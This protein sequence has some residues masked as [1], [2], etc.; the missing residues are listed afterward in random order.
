MPRHNFERP[1]GQYQDMQTPSIHQLSHWVPP[2]GFPRQFSGILD[3][4]PGAKSAYSLRR[5]TKNYKGPL[6]RGRRS[7]D[8]VEKDFGFNIKNDLDIAA[9]WD[10]LYEN[11]YFTS[12]HI[13]PTFT[14][15]PAST[16]APGTEGDAIYAIFTISIPINPKDGGIFERGATG[17]GV[18]FWI[19]NGN[20]VW[21]VG[22]GTTISGPNVASVTVDASPYFGKTVDIQIFA[23]NVEDTLRIYIREHGEDQYQLIGST[24]I[25]FTNVLY[26]FN[27][28][29][30]FEI[31]SPVRAGF[32]DVVSDCIPIG[33][34]LVWEDTDTP[35]I[36]NILTKTI[37]DLFIPIWYD[38]SGNI[39]DFLQASFTNQPL[40]ITLGILTI[41][42]KGL[43]QIQY[44]RSNLTN[45]LATFSPILSGSDSSIFF[46]THQLVAEGGNSGVLITVPVGDDNS[47]GSPASLVFLLRSGSFDLRTIRTGLTVILNDVFDNNS[48][49]LTS[50]M[51]SFLVTTYK[52]SV[53]QNQSMS[54]LNAL[55]TDR[56]LLGANFTSGAPTSGTT[57]ASGELLLYD[58]DTAVA[59]PGI[60][61]GQIAYWIT[62][63]GNESY[64]DG[65][66]EGD[67]IYN[68]GAESGEVLVSTFLSGSSKKKKRSKKK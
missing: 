13:A 17:D 39:F 42:T 8:D 4:F 38:Q 19:E 31:S 25:T 63:T 44:S 64:N 15:N 37:S 23:S 26:G 24:A 12:N 14:V 55:N 21:M 50:Q 29:S 47:T 3:E 51:N 16:Y 7:G 32:P 65:V 68:D 43:P 40:I 34:F 59:R 27:P 33:P 2:Q 1:D 57:F 66:Q 46:Q 61:A 41:N 49:I 9:L 36:A 30:Y 28:G 53:F 67:L 6:F 18:G 5:L 56:F 35:L 20:F 10:F 11:S 52:D 45:H 62:I 54:P 48:H 58:V 60:E 22:D